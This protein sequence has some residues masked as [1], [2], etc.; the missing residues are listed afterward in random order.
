MVDK[1]ALGKPEVV[2]PSS[3]SSPEIGL[4]KSKRQMNGALR[5]GSAAK[6]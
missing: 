6:S 2:A 1:A 4:S 3:Q 5:E